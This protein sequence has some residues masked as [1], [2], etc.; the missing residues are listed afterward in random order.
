M[1]RLGSTKNGN[2]LGK[3]IGSVVNGSK[4]K[5]FVQSQNQVVANTAVLLAGGY[6]N[7]RIISFLVNK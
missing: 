7:K 1:A 4:G 5:N 3:N 6:Q 2:S